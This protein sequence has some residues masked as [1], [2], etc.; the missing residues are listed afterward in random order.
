MALLLLV[1]GLGGLSEAIL[2]LTSAP[3]GHQPSIQLVGT[4]ILAY[5]ALFASG[6]W[7]LR[8]ACVRIF[9]ITLREAL[10]KRDAA[11]QPTKHKPDRPEGAGRAIPLPTCPDW[12]RP[13]RLDAERPPPVV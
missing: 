8:W 10:L 1:S 11:S 7:A 13:N 6:L 12:P 3:Q 4:F 2:W 5:G 9:H